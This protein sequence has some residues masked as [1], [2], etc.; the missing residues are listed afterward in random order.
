MTTA[1]KYQY[2]FQTPPLVCDFMASLVP[3]HVRT[4]LEPTPGQGNLLKALKN[5]KLRVTSPK[6]FFQLKQQRFDCVVMNPPFSAKY[7][8]GLSGHMQQQGMR[9]GYLFLH[10]C[11]T[12]SDTLIALMPW[13]TLTDSDVRMRN[14]IRFGLKDM[15]AL[16]RKTFQ[17]T[18]IQTLI[19][20]LQKGYTGSTGFRALEFKHNKLVFV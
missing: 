2:D 7:T 8:H 4:V 10:Q 6:D 3:A 12:L 5:R 14:L 16:P 15:Y 20:V 13:F 1:A 11:M 19:L 9:V 17:Y 18:R